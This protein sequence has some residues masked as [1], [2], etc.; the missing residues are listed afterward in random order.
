MPTLEELHALLEAAEARAATEVEVWIPEKPGDR[1]SGV[2]VELGT[3]ST[4]F[5]MYNT[6]TLAVHGGYVEN[7]KNMEGA[8]KLVRVAWMGAVLQAQY[9]RFR[10]LPD[11][12]VAFHYQKNVTP[13]IVKGN[14]YA[15]IE[16]VVIDHTTG[17]AK[18][19]V[20]IAVQV[21][22]EEQLRNVNPETGEITP[23]E[24]A[25]TPGR[26]PATEPLREGEEPL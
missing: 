24:T 4:I 6:S 9:L 17:K 15:L 20:E 8:G 11:N 13:A 14:D 7:G 18:L 25:V 12:I 2:V 19:P 16:S 5:G 3:I 10:P 1:I 21:P 26:N 22:T 23:E